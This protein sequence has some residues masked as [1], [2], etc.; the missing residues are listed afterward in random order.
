MFDKTGCEDEKYLINMVSAE[1]IIRIGFNIGLCENSRV[2]DLCC[3]YGTMLKIWN[4]AFGISGV[5][6]DRVSG[7]IE[8]GRS[9][10]SD[11]RIKLLCG[12]VLRY[13][14]DNLY[15]VVVC[16]EL[17]CGLFA[18]FNE[19]IKFLEN[20]LLP[21][22]TIVFGRLFSELPNPPQE[23]IDFDGFIPTLSE[24]YTEVRQC[25]YLLTSMASGERASWERYI[26]RDAKLSL[27][28]LHQNPGDA[29]H[30]AWTDKWYNMYFN[31]RRPFESWGLF[32]IE[33]I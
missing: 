6:V 15:D 8:T 23:L 21:K 24:I 27:E 26:T 32:G 2:L 14:D 30:T 3:G 13:A 9:R 17:S 10:L 25:G 1:D 16:T 18:D 12:D 7:F 29:E 22:G 20:F 11:D 19:G 5:G 28:K 31:F 33:K 4:E